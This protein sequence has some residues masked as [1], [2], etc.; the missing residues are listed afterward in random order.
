MSV[1]EEA[2]HLTKEYGGVRAL[3]DL[4]FSVESGE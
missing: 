2:E 4:S 3:D 1:L